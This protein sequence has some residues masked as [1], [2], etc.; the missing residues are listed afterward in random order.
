MKPI[1]NGYIL[2]DATYIMLLKW[3]TCRDGEQGTGCG[4]RGAGGN[5]VES[6]QLGAAIRGQQEGPCGDGVILHLDENI[7]APAHN[8]ITHTHTHLEGE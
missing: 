6:G 3:L 8:R 4:G 7:Q 5:K 2:C 1:S